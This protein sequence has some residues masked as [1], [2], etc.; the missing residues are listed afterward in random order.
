VRQ[1]RNAGKDNALVKNIIPRGDDLVKKSSQDRSL[2]AS[3]LRAFLFEKE[4]AKAFSRKEKQSFSLQG[5]I[6]YPSSERKS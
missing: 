1:K 3:V 5:P 6:F 2:K 4:K